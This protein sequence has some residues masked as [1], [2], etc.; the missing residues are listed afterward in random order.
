MEQSARLYICTNLLQ[1]SQ[2]EALNACFRYLDRDQD[3]VITR[4]DLKIALEKTHGKDKSDKIERM[5]QDTFDRVDVKKT[6]AIGYSEFLAAAADDQVLLTKENLRAT[7]DAFDKS[8]TG[9]ITMDDLNEIFSEGIKR[10]SVTKREVKKI[11]QQVDVNGDGEISF[12]EF[13][14]IMRAK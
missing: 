4:N 2:R 5:L 14:S 13:C 11:M 8:K 7:F 3:S 12:D 10:R 6:G 9:T 1:D